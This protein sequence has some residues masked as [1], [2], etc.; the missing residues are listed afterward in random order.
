MIEGTKID[1]AREGKRRERDKHFFLAII[2]NL[3][4]LLLLASC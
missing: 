4:F 1:S 3:S 2:I